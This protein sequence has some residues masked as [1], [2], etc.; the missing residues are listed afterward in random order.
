MT[1]APERVEAAAAGLPDG[2]ADRARALVESL[3]RGNAPEV[4]RLMDEIARMRESSLF[5]ELGRLTR[6]LH[7]ALNN[8]RLDSRIANLAEKDIPDAKERLNYV[9]TMT[10][11]SAHRTLNAVEDSLPVIERIDSSTTVLRQNWQRFLRRELDA[12]QFRDLAQEVDRNLEATAAD[13]KRVR[14]NLN[15]VLM[16]QDFQDITGQMI[17]RVIGLVQQLEGD[18]VELVRISGT[19]LQQVETATQATGTKLEG[20]QLPGKGGA[21]IV[22]NQDDVDAL[23]SSLGF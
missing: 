13:A 16:A 12:R 4:S 14:A 2:L 18:L 6:D 7:D 22:Q 3:E 9:I 8:F 10:E 19:R 5:Q 21:E 11:Q 23:L 1:A 20:P 17:R 15:D